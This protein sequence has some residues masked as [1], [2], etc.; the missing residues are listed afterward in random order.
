[1]N[2]FVV[3]RNPYIAAEQ[4]PDKHIVKMPLETCQMLSIIFSKWY[5]DWGTIPK[6]DGTPY[7]TDKGA[8]RSHPCTIWAASAPENLAWMLAHGVALCNEYQY[9]YGK[10][11]SCK[12]TLGHAIKLVT[13]KGK[14]DATKYDWQRVTEFT[15]AM[16]DDLKYDDTIDTPEAYRRYLNTKTWIK[17]NYLRA[18][19]RKPDWIV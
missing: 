1:M 19:H 3:D 12:D 8:F 5:Y 15:R 16:P 11:H 2:I 18:H 4:L 17:D 7:N 10:R 9:R 14:P 13:I 6:A